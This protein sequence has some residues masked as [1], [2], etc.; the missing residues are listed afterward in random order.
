[1]KRFMYC[2]YPL[3]DITIRPDT[4]AMVPAVAYVGNMAVLYFESPQE[5]SPD[6]VVQGRMI[7][8][9]D[10]SNWFP[11]LE[12]YHSFPCDNDDKWQRKLENKKP[13]LRVNYLKHETAAMY[14]YHHIARQE[15][16]PYNG[17]RYLSIFL[18]QSLM[19]MYLEYP[20]E[21]ISWSDIEGKPHIPGRKDWGLL[22][23]PLF[24]PWEDGTTEWRPCS[25]T[26][27]V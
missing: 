1:M 27:T 7:P 9:P 26:R 8:F 24:I 25:E 16:N 5:L 15:G 2:G 20:T 22:L 4:R 11:M 17:D 13:S 23:E 12:I 6:T 14:I 10:G 19:I 21:R 3:E 18:Y